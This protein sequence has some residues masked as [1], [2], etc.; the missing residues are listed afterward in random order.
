[1]VVDLGSLQEFMGFRYRPRPGG[2]NGTVAQYR[3]YVSDDG[4]NWGVP[5]SQGNLA[6]LGARAAVKTVMFGQ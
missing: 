1:M 2:R 5:V 6:A 3:L 4:M